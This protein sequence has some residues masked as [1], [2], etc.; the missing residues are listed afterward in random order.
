[1]KKIFITGATGFIGCRLAEI[2]SERGLT[3]VALVRNWSRAARLARLRAQMVQGDVLELESLRSGMRGCDVVFHCA[4]DNRATGELHRRS[5]AAGTVNVLQAALE[6]GVEQV[7]HVS[8]IAVYGYRAAPAARTETA[9]YSYSSDAYCDGKIDAEKSALEYHEKF[10]LAVTVL[11]P[12]IVYGPFGAWTEDTVRAIRQRRMALIDGG[13]GICNALYVD[14]LVEAMLRAAEEP[15]ARGEVFHI[16][17]AESITWKQFIEAH[18][19]ALSDGYLPLPEVTA[20]ELAEARRTSERNKPS[21]LSQL[22]ALIRDRQFQ[23]LVRSVTPIEQCIQFGLRTA[24]AVLPAESRRAWR[25]RLLAHQNGHAN[26][27]SGTE[28]ASPVF[29][30]GQIDLYTNNVVFE[31]EKARRLLDY[32]PKIDFS[33]GMELTR[34]WIRWARL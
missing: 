27:A 22:T 29:S 4:V 9:P 7:V 6:A 34:E 30:Q 2:A 3:V 33:R 25:E 8:S 10:H 21:S 14:N 24:R 18:A 17:D 20:V 31:I 15:R 12:T 19:R 16:S 32:D 26:P 13:A 28:N 11:R 5:S 1:M 23:G